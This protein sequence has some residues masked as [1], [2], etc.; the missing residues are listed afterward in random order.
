MI[1]IDIAVVT[2]NSQKWIDSFLN[3]IRN[4]KYDL[5]RLH[6]YFK[7]NGSSD[8]TV[9]LLEKY[10]Y[11][12]DFDEY[13]V[14]SENSNIGFGA[15]SNRAAQMGKSPYI[16]FLN[17][18]TEI[19]EDAFKELNKKV[20][21]SDESVAVWEMRQFPYEHPKIYSP[22]TLE[23][24]WVSGACFLLRRDIFDI[25]G[26]FDESIFMYGEDVE[27]SWRIRSMG[28][29]LMYVP[30]S[31]VYHYAYASANEIKP[32]QYYGSLEA[33]IMLRWRYG[34]ITQI[35]AGYKFLLK[36]YFKPAHFADA[37]K[38]IFHIIIKS[39]KMGVSFRN[40]YGKLKNNVAKFLRYDYEYARNGAFY[41]NERFDKNNT[42]LV[43]VIVRTCGRPYVLE[44]CLKSIRNQTYKNI[45]VCIAEDGLPVS[46]GFIKDRF[47]DMNIKYVAT[48]EKKGRSNAGNRALEMATGKYL[49]FLDDD[50]VF[51]CDHIETM[52]N[53]A[54]KNPD[55][56]MFYSKSFETPI[57]IKTREPYVYQL[58][59]Y[60]EVKRAEYSSATLI[61]SN[62]FPIQTV[63]F[64]REVYE[65]KGGFSTNYEYLEDWDLWLK[66]S[67]IADYI[68]VNK[69]TSEYRVPAV[70][71]IAKERVVLLKQ[72][73]ETI[74]NKYFKLSK[75]AVECKSKIYLTKSLIYTIDSVQVYSKS[76]LQVVGWAIASK[77][78]KNA[79]VLVCITNKD[80]SKLYFNTHRYKRID[81]NEEY[82]QI[83]C[84]DC[85][86]SAWIP[87]GKHGVDCIRTI[88]FVCKK[89][90]KFYI[91]RNF[92]IRFYKF[93]KA[94]KLIVK[95]NRIKNMFSANANRI[96][97]REV[98]AATVFDENYNK[99]KKLYSQKSIYS[100][101]MRCNI[102][103]AKIYCGNVLVVVGWC[104]LEGIKSEAVTP[105]LRIT[106]KRKK[107]HLIYC[108]KEIRKDVVKIFLDNKYLNSGFVMDIDLDLYRINKIKKIE[109]LA[110][111]KK[112]L[113]I[114]SKSEYSFRQRMKNFV[115]SVL[116]HI[117]M[118]LNNITV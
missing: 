82:P 97:K 33:N 105:I 76:S 5:K 92:A 69:T 61:M 78:L 36:A 47:P 101:R 68:L 32:V 88:E 35:I 107:V 84:K 22:V 110:E 96:N 112:K 85:G 98:S 13:K 113:Y 75:K 59:E 54:L 2:Y 6:L 86:V 95:L 42:P 63:F 44:E 100:R 93:E 60:Y 77:E 37:K 114:C 26:G 117:N 103:K 51:Y 83:D 53:A 106:D 67:E 99:V 72:N 50:D 104:L 24:S 62:L 34:N 38:N 71:N 10:E 80:G 73:E 19:E 56:K 9:E 116:Y 115:V 41:E 7:D 20:Q 12:A 45:E 66:Y 90:D 31:C 14:V 111:Y 27:L 21:I 65:Q 16:L 94:R 70:N 87:L 81:V 57:T 18:D 108:E 23:T 40:K 46:E 109:L 15:G 64:K 29:K 39:F 102:D 48:I 8:R 43:S 4:S 11:K 49:N 91:N 17:V 89:N 118:L 74:R 52:V 58:K 55:E 3:A 79:D 30:D 1:N 28:Y 25:T